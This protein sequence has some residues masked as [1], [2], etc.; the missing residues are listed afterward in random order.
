ML[1]CSLISVLCVTCNRYFREEKSKESKIERFIGNVTRNTEITFEYGVRQ[2][3]KKCKNSHDK[4]FE[5]L[6][7]TIPET[8]NLT[9][10]NITQNVNNGKNLCFV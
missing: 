8:E 1:S 6:I 4:C 3:K 5:P 10:G 2:N 7:E 9:A